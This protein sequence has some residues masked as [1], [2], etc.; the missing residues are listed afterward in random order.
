[1]SWKLYSTYIVWGII[2]SLFLFENLS[3]FRLLRK[4]YLYIR[5]SLLKMESYFKFSGKYYSI[6]LEIHFIKKKWVYLFFCFFRWWD[7]KIFPVGHCYWLLWMIT[8]VKTANGKHCFGRYEPGQ[9]YRPH[10]DY[11]SDEVRFLFEDHYNHFQHMFIFYI[12]LR[13]WIP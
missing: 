1:M 4:G 11:F 5:W 3:L 10:Y 8:I 6:L 9:F 12:F 2:P 13:S 7:Q